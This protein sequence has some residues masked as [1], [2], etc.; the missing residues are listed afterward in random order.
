M[1]TAVPWLCWQ[2]FAGKHIMLTSSMHFNLLEIY[3][4]M[5]YTVHELHWMLWLSMCQVFTVQQQNLRKKG[6]LA[7]RKK[8][9]YQCAFFFIYD[10]VPIGN[11]PS[12][13]AF[14]FSSGAY[15][16]KKKK[17]GAGHEVA[18]EQ[19]IVYLSLLYTKML[20]HWRIFFF[21]SQRA[22][23]LTQAFALTRTKAW[24]SEGRERRHLLSVV[25]WAHV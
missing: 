14:V 7:P 17:K 19:H 4:G 25:C 10:S 9:C 24:F 22:L 3:S 23:R 8:S 11:Q 16:C 21:H 20:L 12:D 13:A 2:G 18:D 5:Q 15:W 6:V 1:W